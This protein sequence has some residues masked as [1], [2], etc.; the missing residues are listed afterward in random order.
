MRVALEYARTVDAE[1]YL[2]LV[3]ALAWF[4]IIKTHIVEGRD[5]L[6]LRSNY[7]QSNHRVPHEPERSGAQHTCS[8][9]KAKHLRRGHG[10]TKLASVA[11]PG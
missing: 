7:L 1:K 4:W 10:S 3:G 11:R 2:D 6:K 9:C 5:H 8:P